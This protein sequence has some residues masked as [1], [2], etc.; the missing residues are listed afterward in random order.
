MNDS[1]VADIG[2]FAKYGLLRAL[3][4]PNPPDGQ[5]SLSI[6]VVWYRTPNHSSVPCGGNTEKVTRKYLVP[7][8]HNLEHFAACDPHVYSGLQIINSGPLSLEAVRRQGVLPKGTVFV[9]DVLTVRHRAGYLGT[10]LTTV[11]PCDIVFLDPDNGIID[12]S[13]YLSRRSVEH[14]YLD[15]IQQ[16]IT[17]GKSLVVY[18]HFDHNS[19]A[20]ESIADRFK[21]LLGLAPH[22]RPF[23]LRW[24]RVQGRAFLVLPSTQHNALLRQ[25]ANAML[26]GPWGR[27]Y[28]GLTQ[29]HFTSIGL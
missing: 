16:F 20:E 29:P 4:S 25:R 15:E 9:E 27:K 10:A 23:A 19:L 1:F 13:P 22:R 17:L 8:T 28:V 5:P 14:C 2:D 11:D 3:C 7:S 12:T 24:R 26:A 18:Q 21:D 6:G